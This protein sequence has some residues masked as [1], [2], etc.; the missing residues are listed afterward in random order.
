MQ[1]T[2]SFEVPVGEGEDPSLREWKAAVLEAGGLGREE[3]VEV[4]IMT[5]LLSVLG[6]IRY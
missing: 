2:A 6:W 4:R 5:D 3:A 1:G